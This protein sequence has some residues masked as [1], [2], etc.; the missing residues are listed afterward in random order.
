MLTMR[1][2]LLTPNAQGVKLTSITFEELCTYYGK[3]TVTYGT[4]FRNV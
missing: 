1:C 3:E 2:S 4:L